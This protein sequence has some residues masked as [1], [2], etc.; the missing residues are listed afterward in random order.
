MTWSRP[1][2]W[3]DAAKAKA[4]R[5]LFAPSRAAERAYFKQL[6]GVADQVAGLLKGGDPQAMQARLRD[7]A[8]ALDPW[9]QQAAANMVKAVAR[10]NDASWRSAAERWGIDLRG[11]LEADVT[12]A[13]NARI[14]ENIRLI[15]SL[16]GDAAD[17]VGELAQKALLSGERVDQVAQEIAAQGDVTRHRAR[18]IALTEVS[19][20]GAALTQ[21]R[22][23]SVG[24]EGYIWRTARDGQTR[25]SHAAM[26]GRF[27][28]WDSPPTLDNMTGHAGEF[29]NCRCYPEPVVHDSA[30]KSAA[31]PLPTAEQERAA[32]RHEL[33]SQWERQPG[34]T[35]VP[36]AEGEPLPNVERAKFLPEKLTA[37]SMDPASKTGGADKARVWKEALGM[38]KRHAASVERQIMEQLA[39]RPAVRGKSDKEGE[40]FRVLVPVTGPNGRTVDVVA[41]WIYDRDKESGRFISTVPR[42]V[43]CFVR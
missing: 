14:Q 40:R 38:D 25:P 30:G 27:V 11:M 24:S 3:E 39:G 29:P 10:K 32:G 37:Y 18:V 4:G 31:A 15:K 7:Y 35:V 26:E 34:S 28:R 20:A 16:P 12:A 2:S 9:A 21:A 8:A 42:L 19:K 43:T 5:N 22:A 17:R 23:E 33:R 41:A 6:R 36:H 13:V 1:W